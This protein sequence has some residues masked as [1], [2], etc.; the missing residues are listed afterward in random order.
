[1]IEVEDCVRAEDGSLACYAKGSKKWL[2]KIVAKDV[3][4]MED[5]KTYRKIVPVEREDRLSA[6]KLYGKILGEMKEVGTGRNWQWLKSGFVLKSVK[7]FICA[8]Q[9]QTLRTRC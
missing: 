6:K 8:A 2:M 5:G 4:K 9:E 1:M 7:W 3:E